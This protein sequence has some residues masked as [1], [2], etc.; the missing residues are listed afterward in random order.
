MQNQ[1]LE[2]LYNDPEITAILINRLKKEQE[3]NEM[4]Y[5]AID[6]IRP[7][8]EYFDRVLVAENTIPI[9]IIAKD[10]GMS[11]VSFNK[12]LN[13]L[14]VQYRVRG[15]WVL[16]KKYC[17]KGYTTTGTYTRKNKRVETCTHWTQKGRY[18]LY[19]VLGSVDIY[20]ESERRAAQ[21]RK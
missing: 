6:L 10:Y 21:C 16:Y 7:K 15:T 1:A 2:Y 5:K 12:L 19:K 4:L 3:K 13:G 9:T 17:N 8:A 11:A 14:R 18:F 20:P